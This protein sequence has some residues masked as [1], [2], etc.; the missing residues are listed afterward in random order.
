M[1]GG[2]A[3]DVQ[4]LKIRYG[5]GEKGMNNRLIEIINT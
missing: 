2:S 5:K 4:R 1:C 3:H